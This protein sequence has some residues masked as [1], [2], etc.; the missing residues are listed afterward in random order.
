MQQHA[1]EKEMYK[2]LRLGSN[3]KSLMECE[4]I[5]NNKTKLKSEWKN[6]YKL[7]YK[8]HGTNEIITLNNVRAFDDLLENAKNF[9]VNEIELILSFKVKIIVILC[10]LF[11]CFVLL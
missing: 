8:N 4:N 7:S 1:S 3:I 9:N 2:I 5:I 10:I 6:Y 11:C